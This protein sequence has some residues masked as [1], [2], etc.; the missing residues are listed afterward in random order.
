MENN[1]YG[2]CFFSLQLHNNNHSKL[3]VADFCFVGV[4]LCMC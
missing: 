3:V 1:S 4:T 2:F